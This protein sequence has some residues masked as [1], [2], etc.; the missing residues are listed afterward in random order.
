[1]H[2]VQDKVI[3]V[4]IFGYLPLFFAAVAASRRLSFLPIF[5]STK[6]RPKTAACVV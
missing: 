4:R 3:L 5:Q 2:S 6:K 1:L